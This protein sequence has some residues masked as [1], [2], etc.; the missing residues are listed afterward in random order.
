M[1]F[2]PPKRVYNSKL[3]KSASA[4]ISSKDKRPWKI[5]AKLVSYFKLSFLISKA[6][7]G[8]QPQITQVHSTCS[9]QGIASINPCDNKAS[10]SLSCPVCDIEI[11]YLACAHLLHHSQVQNILSPLLSTTNNAVDMIY[12]YYMFYYEAFSIFVT[13]MRRVK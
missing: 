12:Q 8:K 2:R 3:S 5:T 4:C 6:N 10:Y 13:N 1:N 7:N 11:S 9:S